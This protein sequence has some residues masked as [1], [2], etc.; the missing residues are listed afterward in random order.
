MKLLKK[1][2]ITLGGTVKSVNFLRGVR[3][4]RTYLRQQVKTLFLPRTETN[5]VTTKV[6]Q[7]TSTAALKTVVGR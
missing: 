6:L 3:R 2:L 1:P 5:P 7:G 4:L